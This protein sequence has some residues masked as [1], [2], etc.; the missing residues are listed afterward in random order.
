[1]ALG[2]KEKYDKEDIKLS[3][4]AKAISHPARVEILRQISS[5]NACFFHEI[6][7][8]LPL[9]DSTVSQHLMELKNAGLVEGISDP[10]RV[11]YVI[12]I[13]ELKAARKLLKNFT[14]SI[15]LKA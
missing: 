8:A 5:M 9:A 13:D 14:K 7:A 12:N 6:S 2:K 4:I 10:P 11:K 15:I 3:R 1:M